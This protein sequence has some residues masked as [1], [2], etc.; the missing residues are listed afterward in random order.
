MEKRFTRIASI[1][2]AIL[3]V[4]SAHAGTGGITNLQTSYIN[5]YSEVYRDADDHD[6]VSTPNTFINPRA[7]TGTISGSHSATFSGVMTATD[8][9]KVDVGNLT[10]SQWAQVDAPSYSPT[11][12]SYSLH[13]RSTASGSLN[14]NLGTYND[15]IANLGTAIVV[16]GPTT[17]SS[18][19]FHFSVDGSFTGANGGTNWVSNTGS[20]MGYL[21][22]IVWDVDSTGRVF[23]GTGL[24]LLEA[25][26]DGTTATMDVSVPWPFT[27]NDELAFSLELVAFARPATLDGD[28]SGIYLDSNLSD[29]GSITG[30]TLYDAAG[31]VITGDTIQDAQMPLA[32]VP[33]PASV[34]LMAC[35]CAF[36]ALRRN[37]LNRAGAA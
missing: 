13:A 34:F 37:T 27:Y 22:F 29:T 7:L 30:M 1:S 19:V 3:A 12:L 15:A 26:L 25:P 31:K 36:L 17:P 6:D 28:A 8:G 11:G 9:V 10:T 35:G 18:V 23:Q 5:E 33:E 21:D 32:A 24:G 16:S 4:A 14:A 2:G 20:D